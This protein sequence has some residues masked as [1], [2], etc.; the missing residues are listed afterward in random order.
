M[1]QTNYAL[2]QLWLYDTSV[3]VERHFAGSFLTVEIV[4][5]D[6]IFYCTEFH[7]P[8]R[9]RTPCLTVLK[10][11]VCKEFEKG[12]NFIALLSTHL[13]SYRNTVLSW[14]QIC[15]SQVLYYIKAR[16][17]FLSLLTLYVRTISPF[18]ILWNNKIPL[19]L[20][21]NNCLVTCSVWKSSRH[22]IYQNCKFVKP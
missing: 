16:I 15:L 19:Q 7:S 22:R 17:T 6:T 3:T 8:S 11:F 12:D 13:L 21:N 2:G 20:W 14:I 9:I 4:N 10:G 1:S 5:T 18:W